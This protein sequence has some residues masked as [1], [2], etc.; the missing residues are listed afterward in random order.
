[1]QSNRK[2][3]QDIMYL[4]SHKR[5]SICKTSGLPLLCD[6]FEVGRCNGGMSL[7]AQKLSR[8]LPCRV[9]P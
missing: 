6:K 3:Q 4:S 1:M 7:Y 5:N 2:L 9:L 8:D